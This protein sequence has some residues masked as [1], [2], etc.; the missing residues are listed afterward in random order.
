MIA[1]PDKARGKTTKDTKYHEG[2][3]DFLRV[4]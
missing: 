2:F 3:L 1:E 4:P